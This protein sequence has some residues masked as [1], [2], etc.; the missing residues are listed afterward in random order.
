MNKKKP[1]N[2]LD[3]IG[4]TP[5]VP[6]SRLNDNKDVALMAKVEGFNPGGSIKFRPALF[7]IEAAEQRGDL[8]KNKTVLEATSGNTGIGLALVCAVKGYR[9]RLAMSESASEERKT[10]LRAY[11][12]E[13]VL[14]PSSL[15]TDGAIEYVY[16]LVRE[17]PDKYF[18]VDQ[19]N[20]PD[21][22]RSHYET[23][24]REILEQTAGNLDAVVVCL[25]TT[26][27]VMGIAR[28]FKEEKPEVRIVAIEP[29][30]G[31]KIQGLKNMKES[32]KPGIY[33]ESL[34]DEVVHVT[35][36]EA[37][38]ATQ[39]L[40]QMEG[41]F[42]GISSG[43]A[44]AGALKIVKT[45]K[46]GTV[47]TLLPD[48]G[49]RYL[50]TPVFKKD[51]TV[52]SKVGPFVYNTLARK[53]EPLQTTP[54]K[55]IRMYTCGPTVDSFMHLGLCRRFVTADIIRRYLE[56]QGLEVYHVVN[57]TDLDDRTIRAAEAAGI[58]LGQ[59]TEKYLRAFWEDIDRLAVRRASVYPR[60]TENIDEMIALVKKLIKTGTAYEKYRSIYFDVTRS[61]GT[62]DCRASTRA[63][64]SPA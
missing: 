56:Y 60:V 3:G 23:T 62:G 7:M 22:W 52:E 49:E 21:N 41:L 59:L 47:V 35:D 55:K 51:D 18:L 57:I 45:M 8:N 13:L 14:T 40:A 29:N 20:N 6:I 54:R 42:V 9:L 4:H 39:R 15:G 27:T 34:I 17:A 50:S 38:D 30:P 2:I 58:P 36:D 63:R 37:F 5:L 31:H 53:K 11:G 10:I 24:A 32:Y 33:D 16:N 43:A 12:A 25:G 44:V 64:S 46:S 61:G 48:F 26:G 1:S 28:R 19:Y